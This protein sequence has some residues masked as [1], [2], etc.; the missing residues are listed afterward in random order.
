MYYCTLWTCKRSTRISKHVWLLHM[1]VKLYW[2]QYQHLFSGLILSACMEFQFSMPLMNWVLDIAN[3]YYFLSQSNLFSNF[4]DKQCIHDVERRNEDIIC[5]LI[6]W[7]LTHCPHSV[8]L[9]PTYGNHYN[10]ILWWHFMFE[11]IYIPLE[12]FGFLDSLTV[13][14]KPR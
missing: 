8:L 1:L 14:V 10:I 3:K 4:K 7:L 5:G 6:N 2:C 12:M 13:V 11:Y 9:R